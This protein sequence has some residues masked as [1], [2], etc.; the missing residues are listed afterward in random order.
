MFCQEEHNF[1]KHKN[2]GTGLNKSFRYRIFDSTN[3]LPMFFVIFNPQ[4]NQP[5]F[6][7]RVICQ[8]CK[9]KDTDLYCKNCEVFLCNECSNHI[10]NNDEI[11]TNHELKK[12][13]KIQK[14]GKCYFDQERDVEFFCK[15]CN[16]P[17]C[18]FCRVIGSHSKGEATLHQFEDINSAFI[19]FSPESNDVIKLCEE[20]K[21]KGYEN[22]VKI[23]YQVE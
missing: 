3:I 22:L 13:K 8:E 19:R 12:I 6:S 1:T 23:K 9:T 11:T 15:N 21:K 5:A 14:P 16:I 2:S 10:H 4:S 18:S 7:S 20:M 17:I